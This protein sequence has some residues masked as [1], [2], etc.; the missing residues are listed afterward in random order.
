M[1]LSKRS[2]NDLMELYKLVMA[3]I[4]RL[5]DQYLTARLLCFI[6]RCVLAEIKLRGLEVIPMEIH[7]HLDLSRSKPAPAPQNLPPGIPK[8]PQIPMK[9]PFENFIAR[10]DLDGFDDQP[11][12]DQ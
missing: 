1:N 3:L 5:G 8:L 4:A 7:F 12:V 2:N 11:G 10:L 9:N 6:Q